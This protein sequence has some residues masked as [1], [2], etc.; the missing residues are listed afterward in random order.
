MRKITTLLGLLLV[1]CACSQQ[2]EADS[3]LLSKTESADHFY[4]VKSTE[5]QVE[6]RGVAQRDKLWNPGTV[7]TVKLLSDPYGMADK[8]H[9]LPNGKSMQMLNLNL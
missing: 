9:M 1:L 4:G 6:L 2:E 7:I 8:K 5:G 3:S